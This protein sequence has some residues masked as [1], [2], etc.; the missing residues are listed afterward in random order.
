MDC[1]RK[2][3]SHGAAIFLAEFHRRIRVKFTLTELLHESL[4]E[5]PR[6]DATFSQ[7]DRSLKNEDEQNDG[8]DSDEEHHRPAILNHLK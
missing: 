6:N 5:R 8:T 4:D 1:R 3:L 2:D 7:A